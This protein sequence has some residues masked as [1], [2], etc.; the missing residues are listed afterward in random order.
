M[1]RAPD[2]DIVW[3]LSIVSWQP[4]AQT[5]LSTSFKL[6]CLSITVKIV[7]RCD[8]SNDRDWSAASTVA[9]LLGCI[10]I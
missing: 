3:K 5:M 8:P 1:V 7:G 2:C 10:A 9:N 6:P 4:A